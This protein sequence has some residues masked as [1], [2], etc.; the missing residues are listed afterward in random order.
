MFYI[1]LFLWISFNWTGAQDTSR[2]EPLTIDACAEFGYSSVRFPNEIGQSTQ[3]VAQSDLDVL[4]K[5]IDTGCSKDL[6]LFLCSLY[7]HYCNATA[8]DYHIMPCRDLC[9]NVRDRCLATMQEKEHEWPNSWKCGRFPYEKGMCVEGIEGPV[10]EPPVETST[11]H[12]NRKPST[13]Q[14]TVE[15]AEKPEI[16]DTV[17]VDNSDSKCYSKYC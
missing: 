4:Q 16:T 14:P 17:V 9:I 7:A 2:C 3:E 5:F 12:L 15:P 10:T 6:K 1:V 8:M 13:K 11:E